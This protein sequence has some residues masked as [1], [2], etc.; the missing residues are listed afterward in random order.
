MNKIKHAIHIILRS[1]HMTARNREVYFDHFSLKKLIPIHPMCYCL[2]FYIHVKVLLYIHVY[3]NN[4]N[5][6]FTFFKN[7]VKVKTLRCK[8]INA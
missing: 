8:E 5:K 1:G 7:F 2:N 4:K 6:I 3:S